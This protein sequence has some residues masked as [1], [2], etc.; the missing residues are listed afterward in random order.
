M[1]IEADKSLLFDREYVVW[2]E[3]NLQ[4]LRRYNATDRFVAYR[5]KF[6]DFTNST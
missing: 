5:D 4:S 3:M 6:L 1:E 2:G